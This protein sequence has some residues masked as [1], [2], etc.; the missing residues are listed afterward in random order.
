MPQISESR[1]LEAKRQ[2]D[3]R[4]QG[5]WSN[6]RRR[7]RLSSLL[8][9][10]GFFVAL[11]VIQFWGTE[12]MP[13]SLNQ[14]VERDITAR[15]DFE[16]EDR[17]ETDLRRQAARDAAPNVFVAN[18]APLEAVRTEMKQLQD[19]AAAAGTDN[20]KLTAEAKVKGWP[21]DDAA[22]SAIRELTSEPKQADY[23][24]MVADLAKR[25]GAQY[26]VGKPAD[27]NRKSTPPTAIL[28]GEG[29]TA[30]VDNSQLVYVSDRKK[31]VATVDTVLADT[32]TCPRALRAPFSAILMGALTGTDPDK[33]AYNPIWRYS[34]QLTQDKMETA[35]AAVKPYIVSRKA[36]TVLVEAGKVLG[37]PE[38]A[39][40]KMEHNAY[41]Q[42]QKT[43]PL[44][45]Q[46]NLLNQLGTA[47]VIL[48]V[49]IGLAAYIVSYNPR[50]TR[51]P[52]RS[53]MLA[54][55]LLLV[56]ALSR[57]VDRFQGF[58]SDLPAEACVFFIVIAAALLTIAYDQR[59]AF[60]VSAA[61]TVLT[62][63]A[64]SGNPSLF[65]GLFLTYMTAA[66]VTV[67]LLK[68]VR[69][70]SKMIAVGAITALATSIVST[71]TS[72]MAGQQALFVITHM[73]LAG[74]TALF[75]GFIVQGILPQFER[76]FGIATSM[77]L[78]EWCDASRPLLRRLAQETPGTYSHSLVLSQMAEEACEAIGARGLLARVGALYHDIGKAQ[79]PVYFV[80][81]QEASMNRHDRLSP[82][83]SLLIIVG[84]IKDGI[85]MARA[86]GLPKIL[87]Q[88]ILEHH[89]TTVVRYF[90]HI[91][92][93]AAAKNSRI[94]GRHDREIPESEFR[95]P[96]PKPQ[97][98]ES[99][100]LMICDGCE[101]AVR[102]LSE[103]TP[104]RIESTVHQVVMDRL[105]DGQ[106][107]E[108]DI[109]LRELKLVEQSVVKSLCAI[110]HGRIK[111]PK[112]DRQASALPAR[113]AGMAVQEVAVGEAA[114]PQ[115]SELDNRA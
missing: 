69:T 104:G 86:Y 25:L 58:G 3:E 67:S 113:P 19:L 95:Y 75:A 45:R 96:G 55:L 32:K 44:L 2:R 92:S 43:D 21:M 17:S 94:K 54:G 26:V 23:Q 82:T 61:L 103:A 16:Y 18:P 91:A 6:L 101:G 33:P 62:S 14:R 100:L 28:Q 88:F 53:T 38:L 73:A 15:V 66:G 27:P 102:A 9:G 70:R 37:Q 52:T 107:D 56:V 90:H 78:L 71:A 30:E 80:E 97:S 50:I 47:V 59:F 114:D 49:V 41:L 40:L 106:F 109:T 48:L 11:L 77:T 99:A 79:K 76:T 31:L 35:A 60:G 57:L 85:E 29:Q 72:L 84:H 112:S 64:V 46:R 110:H 34:P 1:R 4:R 63:V 81:N 22:A 87:H 93:E 36:G 111:Y 108:C 24:A 12:A 65:F 74:L 13:W 98:K 83:M 89:G 7:V 10:L 42:A 5:F 68:E 20:A 8:I 105:N 115:A 51:D 39:L